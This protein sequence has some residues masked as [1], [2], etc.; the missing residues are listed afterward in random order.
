M[1]ITLQMIE[2]LDKLADMYNGKANGN[3][4]T[5]FWLNEPIDIVVERDAPGDRIEAFHVYHGEIYC[6]SECGYD[7]DASRLDAET[8]YN[9]IN[10]IKDP[11]N[12]KKR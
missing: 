12:V 1:R 5:E 4:V 7:I 2:D 6:I 9:L 11:E 3:P 8:L 10:Y